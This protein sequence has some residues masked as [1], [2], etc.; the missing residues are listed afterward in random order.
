[1]AQVSK[2]NFVYTQWVTGGLVNELPEEGFAP[3]L[4][5]IYWAK[6]AAILVARTSRPR[7]GCVVRYQLLK[8]GRALGS[9]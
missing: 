8:H 5:N 6:G 3:R 7:I 9:K 4:I 2:K 1:M